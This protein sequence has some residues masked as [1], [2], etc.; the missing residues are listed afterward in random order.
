VIETLVELPGAES[1]NGADEFAG[2]DP[3]TPERVDVN[4][5]V[6]PKSFETVHVIV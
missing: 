6:V 2:T 3:D 1:E 4:V 5:I